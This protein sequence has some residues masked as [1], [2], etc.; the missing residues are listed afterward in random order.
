MVAHFPTIL[1]QVDALYPR[2]RG[3]LRL[4]VTRNEPDCLSNVTMF[5]GARGLEQ[6]YAPGIINS[7]DYF[8]HLTAS[9][10]M[11]SMDIATV[12]L[13]MAGILLP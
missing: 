5:A 7:L 6:V 11:S 10:M 13:L 12:S 8:E 4:V 2:S 9:T 3:A 1:R